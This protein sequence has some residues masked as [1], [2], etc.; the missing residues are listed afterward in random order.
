MDRKSEKATMPSDSEAPADH[1]SAGVRPSGA[2]MDDNTASGAGV[3]SGSGGNGLKLSAKM[4]SGDK[5]QILSDGRMMNVAS[6]IMNDAVD[7]E[8]PFEENEIVMVTLSA[9]DRSKVAR[10]SK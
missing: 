10:I 5:V 6:D 7:R 9:A 3:D 1:D 4:V 2:N 8:G